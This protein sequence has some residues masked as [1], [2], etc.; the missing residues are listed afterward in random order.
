MFKT[1][2]PSK[3]GEAQAE[4]AAGKNSPERTRFGSTTDLSKTI[5]VQQCSLLWCK[6]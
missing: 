3:E 5:N 2:P 1:P 6:R 4:G